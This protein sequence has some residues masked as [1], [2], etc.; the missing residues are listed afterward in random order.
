M[1]KSPLR[2]SAV[3]REGYKKGLR[4]AL[5]IINEMVGESEGDKRSE[6][7]AAVDEFASKNARRASRLIRARRNLGS[8]VLKMLKS[9]PGPA[10]GFGVTHDDDGNP[11]CTVDVIADDGKSSVRVS[12]SE[13]DVTSA[14]Y[15]QPDDNV[16][17]F[18]AALQRQFDSFEEKVNRWLRLG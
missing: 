9:G 11:V 6:L 7:D 5:A 18:A 15:N 10:T 1:R 17:T 12:F 16:D 14:Y 3:L 13:N 8:D 4:E 2:K